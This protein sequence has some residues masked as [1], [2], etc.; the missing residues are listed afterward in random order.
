ML[1]SHWPKWTII[2]I[3]LALAVFAVFF[4][5][6]LEP[7]AQAMM[8]R[9]TPTPILPM[10]HY[11]APQSWD[12]IFCHTNY[13]KLRQFVADEAKLERLWIDPADIYSTHGRL[14]CVTCHRGTGNTQD[15]ALAHQGLVPNPSDYREAAKVCVICHGNVRTDIPEKHIHTP[16]ER[17]LKGIREGWEVCACS[18]CHGP[19]AHGEKPL[20][21]HEGLAAYCVDCHQA[22]NVP[23]ERL[24]CSG[25]HIAPHDIALDCETCHRSTRTWS[26]VR[27]A[28]HPV[29]LTG[30]HAQ[31]ACFDCHKKP[32]FRGLR[33]VCSDCH[34]RPH[35]FGDENCERCHTPE[36][37]RK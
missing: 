22:K 13:E 20:A 14:G 31:L 1:P 26:N 36:G 11:A 18:N 34:Q 23:P 32:N 8:P 7:V 25:C 12:C 37:W 10:L 30:A 4:G 24:K 33:Y 35:T 5:L 28:V 3:A 17:I 27:L 2:L 6:V 16:H 9:P 15:V 21:S 19:V 29:E